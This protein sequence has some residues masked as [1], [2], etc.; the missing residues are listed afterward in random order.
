MQWSGHTTRRVENETV[1]VALDV[2]GEDEL[3]FKLCRFVEIYY[4]LCLMSYSRN[5]TRMAALYTT[6]SYVQR[7]VLYEFFEIYLV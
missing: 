4:R 3:I 1:I 7:G 5:K 6:A 2:L